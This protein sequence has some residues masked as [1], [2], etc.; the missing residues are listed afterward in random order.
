MLLVHYFIIVA[1]LLE[2][3]S[4]STNVIQYWYSI[5]LAVIASC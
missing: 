3:N 5:M 2:I 1:N 4:I